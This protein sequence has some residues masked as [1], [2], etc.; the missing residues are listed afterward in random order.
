MEQIHVLFLKLVM[1][2]RPQGVLS[3]PT[4]PHLFNFTER[5]LNRKQEEV[6]GNSLASFIGL[7]WLHLEFTAL[8]AELPTSPPPKTHRVSVQTLTQRGARVPLQLPS[9]NTPKELSDDASHKSLAPE[10]SY[11]S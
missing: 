4:P 1:D 8:D 9:V 3:P 10:S 5:Q 7:Y 2:S 11:L 6:A